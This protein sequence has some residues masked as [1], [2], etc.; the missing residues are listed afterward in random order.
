MS[1][2]Y[3]FLRMHLIKPHINRQIPVV[4]L[5][6]LFSAPRAYA[7]YIPFDTTAPG[8]IGVGT[9]TPQAKFVVIG[10]NMGIGTWTANSALN[11]VGN[12]GIGSIT[13]N[14]SLDVG[15][16]G[17]ICFGSNCQSTWPSGSGTNYWN[18]SSSGNIG[19]STSAAVGIGTTFIGG[20]GEAALSVMNGNVGIGTWVSGGALIVNGN[21]GIGTAS[22]NGLFEARSQGAVAA[23]SPNFFVVD[24]QT[25][26]S[27]PGSPN[28]GS[29]L[30]NAG[31]VAGGITSGAGGSITLVAGGG[32]GG[33]GSAGNINITAG[34]APSAGITAGNVTINPGAMGK[35]PYV[36]LATTVGN[37]GI[38]TTTPA[39]GLAVMNGNVGIGTWVPGSALSVMNGN[40]GIGSTAPGGSLDVG[41]SGTICL[42]SSC[43]SSWP[44]GSGTNYWN[45][46]SAGNIGVS[47]SAA[48]GIG[49]T[50][51]GGAGEAELAVINGNVGIGTWVPVDLF[52][53]GKYKSSSSGFEVDSNG[54]VGM[55]TTLTTTAALSVMSGSVGIGTVNPQA[56]LELNSS[57]S[58]NTELLDAYSNT[59]NFTEF[60]CT[61]ANT[62]N[63][64]Q[65]GYSATANNGTTTTNFGYFG[66]NNS[67]FSTSAAYDVGVAGD[68]E[69]LS[70]DN[71]L[72]IANGSSGKSINFYTG[73]T[74]ASNIHVTVD[75]SGNV[76]IGTTITSNAGLS[77]MN[78]NVGIG[79]WV[80]ASRLAVNGGFTQSVVTLTF[81]GTV[82]TNAA[83]GNYFRIPS[84]TSNFTLESPTNPTDGQRIIWEIDQAGSGSYNAV[85][86]S[87]NFALGTDIS[88]L[89]SAST[90]GEKDFLTAVYNVNTQEWY[91]VAFVRGYT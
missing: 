20:T 24:G 81:G 87:T 74:A 62:G 82:N 86:T 34:N 51:I 58:S 84:V 68:V 14:G 88:S 53:V 50:F 11:V 80:P 25:F 59:N 32:S 18:Y 3:F 64:A 4:F 7:A 16:T 77:V 35:S 79:T 39:G 66:I 6:L 76:G 31:S 72:D 61:N 19:V 26:V 30:L 75:G 70:L 85:I 57:T 41:P 12:V 55:G 27:S 43:K 56:L 28:G 5:L 71:N 73:G 89:T 38:G 17:T 36:L 23:S 63:N 44:S 90:S 42:G 52:Q 2:Y 49:T 47:T 69:V 91:I 83:L 8:N 33:G 60:N 37:V 78:G 48:V 54:N 9:S 46:S 67:G 29:I 13:P 1:L 40:V 22:A 10:G 45:Y 21:V 65:C 15:P